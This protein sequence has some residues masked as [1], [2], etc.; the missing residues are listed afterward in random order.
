M[1]GEDYMTIILVR[2]NYV[3]LRH[4]NQMV[5]ECYPGSTIVAFSSAEKAI[6]MIKNMENKSI[7]ALPKS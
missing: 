3:A 4:L 6:E 5:E 2:E 7:F 1:N